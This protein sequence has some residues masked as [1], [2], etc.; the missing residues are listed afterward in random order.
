MTEAMR[1]HTSLW[2]GIEVAGGYS[3]QALL[4]TFM[5]DPWT[6]KN[7]ASF[8]GKACNTVKQVRVWTLDPD[9]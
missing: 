4:R 1:Q 9:C 8:R 7:Q 6:P 5:A 3:E 2:I